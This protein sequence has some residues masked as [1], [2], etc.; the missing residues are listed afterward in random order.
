MTGGSIGRDLNPAMKGL[1]MI[2]KYANVPT[3]IGPATP[4]QHVRTDF[5]SG[6]EQLPNEIAVKTPP[7]VLPDDWP[8]EHWEEESLP[9][10]EERQFQKSRFAMRIAWWLAAAGL[11]VLFS[12]DSANVGS[13][14]IG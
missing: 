11:L 13:G 12:P 3:V 6:I 2:D 7:T 9:G 1:Y 5:L 4:S 8:V 10:P 14:A